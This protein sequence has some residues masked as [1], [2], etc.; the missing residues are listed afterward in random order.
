MCSVPAVAKILYR[1]GDFFMEAECFVEL[2]DGKCPDDQIAF[3]A[4]GR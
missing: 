2:V 1:T 3:Y 4:Y